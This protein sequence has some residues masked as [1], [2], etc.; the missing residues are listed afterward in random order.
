MTSR[1]DGSRVRLCKGAYAEPERVAY[2]DP[3]EVDR[4]YVRCLKI[5]MAGAG[6]PMVATHDPRLIAIGRKLAQS[7]AGPRTASSSRCSTASGPPSS[8]GWPVW[9]TGCGSTCPTARLVRLPDP[10][11]GR[12]PGQPRLLR[13]QPGHQ[14]LVQQSAADWPVDDLDSGM[15]K[16]LGF[17]VTSAAPF[18][19]AVAAMRQSACQSVTPRAEKP[20]RHSPACHAA[21]RSTESLQSGE[22]LGC[23]TPFSRTQTTD[24]LLDVDRCGRRQVAGLGK[25][26][27]ALDGWPPAQSS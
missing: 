3:Q 7:R 2:T 15:G 1:Y 21:A 14:E 22:Q 16:P 17:P 9:A 12:A 11:A 23:R 27:N 8:S 18:T 5:L 4:S 24:D 19:F 10:P 20:R 6:Y 26:G 13:P 25:G